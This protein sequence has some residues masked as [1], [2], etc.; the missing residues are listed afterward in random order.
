MKRIH[1]LLTTAALILLGLGFIFYPYIS[2][3]W[4]NRRHVAVA[5][6]YYREASQLPQEEIEQHFYRAFEHNQFLY[7][8]NSMRFGDRAPIP[9]D[10]YDIL[11]VS[12]VMA[13]LVIPAI[14]VDLPILHGTTYEAMLNGVAHLEGSSFP[15]GGY[16]TH[17]VFTAHSGMHNVI[18]FSRL[19]E[20]EEGDFF[21]IY[22][23]DQRLVYMVDNI[24]IILPHQV[25]GLAIQPDAD[26]VSLITC[27][28]ITINTH[29]LVVRGRRYY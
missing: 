15:T 27:T 26:L 24:T 10:Y 25:C 29:R 14:N 19:H 28:P 17:A 16:G 6:A 4:N 18:F 11:S 3:W 23:L 20:L 1:I 22:V 8:T 12:G 13:R 21:Y 5:R 2:Q 7:E 9:E